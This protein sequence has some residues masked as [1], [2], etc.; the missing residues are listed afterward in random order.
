[1]NKE[2]KVITIESDFGAGKKGA[3]LGPQATL[4]QLQALGDQIVGNSE[5]IRVQAEG[6]ETE[7]LPP[8]SKNIESI[9]DVHQRALV[10]VE[11]V[12]KENKFSHQNFE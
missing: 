5:V 6:L 8:F 9:F 11:S 2:L 7:N 4:K 12:L 1:M 10:A 3:K